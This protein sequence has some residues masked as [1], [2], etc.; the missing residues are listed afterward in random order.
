[1]R[2]GG[3]RA[4]TGGEREFTFGDVLVRVDP[5]SAL[6]LNI[7]TDEAGAAGV[8]SGDQATIEGIQSEG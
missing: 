4:P 6:A 1:V 5:E 7:D 2:A 3:A 8:Q